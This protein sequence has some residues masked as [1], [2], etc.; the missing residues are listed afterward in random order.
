MRPAMNSEDHFLMAI[1]ADPDDD[2]PRMAYADWLMA[3]KN[4]RGEFIRLQLQ[5]ARMPADH[6]ARPDL[7]RREKS[8]LKKHA[9]AW[10]DEYPQWA[11]ADYPAFH[12]GFPSEIAC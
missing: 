6:P 12:R 9:K 7:E 5:L 11:R 1:A 10:R 8:L 2:A 4:P 3:E